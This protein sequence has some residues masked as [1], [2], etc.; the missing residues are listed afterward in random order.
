M[1]D[2]AILTSVAY[3]LDVQNLPDLSGLESLLAA[4]DSKRMER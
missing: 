1:L 4:I 2:K 3:Y